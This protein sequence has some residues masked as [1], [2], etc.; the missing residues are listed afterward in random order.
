MR[1]IFL[2]FL[3]IGAGIAAQTPPLRAQAPPPEVESPEITRTPITIGHFETLSSEI[4]GEERTLMVRLPP[5]YGTSSARYPVLYL[6]D[7]RTW[8]EHAAGTLGAL[9]RTGHMP[10]SILVGVINTQRA[11]D[12]TPPWT[13][14]ASIAEEEGRDQLVAIGGG[15]ENFLAFF[16]D[17][18]IPEVEK[19]YR[20]APMRLLVGHS[21][22]GLFVLHALTREPDLFAATIAIS[23]SV[24]WDA[25][26]AVDQARELFRQ[27]PQIEH[28]FFLALANEGGE[29]AAQSERLRTFLLHEAP[30]GLRWHAERIDGET[31]GSIPLASLYPALRFSFPRWAVPNYRLDEGL[32]AVDAHFAS[33]ARDFGIPVTTPE[34]TIGYLGRV[35]LGQG[36]SEKAIE[37]FTTNVERYPTSANAHDSLGGALE[38]SG[39]LERA[40]GLYKKALS[41]A[42]AH[43]DDESSLAAFQARIDAVRAKMESP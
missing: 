29:M 14:E 12:L 42:R 11:R 41:L 21:F 43:G 10:E 32:A 9:E 19:R 38:A 23:P 30:P 18:L 24:W 35:A 25:G 20:T 1:P 8:F 4:L 15:A 16:R 13:D 17:E 6:L 3:L 2:A 40:L 37:I 34:S 5:G 26:R 39:E 36:E 7:P 22:G 27:R 28:R 31:H 33:L